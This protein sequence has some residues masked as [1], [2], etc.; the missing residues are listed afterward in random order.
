MPPA[1]NSRF[2]SASRP[3]ASSSA[4]EGKTMAVTAVPPNIAKAMSLLKLDRLL[5]IYPTTDDVLRLAP[6]VTQPISVQGKWRVL[7]TP[8]RLDALTTPELY[9]AAKAELQNAPYLV[10]NLTN[11]IFLASAGMAAIA[12]LSREAVAMN[13]E[14][15]LAGSQGDVARTLELMNFDKVLP[16]FTDMAT[17]TI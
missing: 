13:G 17:A 1:R 2:K 5:A 3:K 10:L 8:V 16:V 15:R 9:L 12:K 6:S 11:T 14:L 4:V 7:H